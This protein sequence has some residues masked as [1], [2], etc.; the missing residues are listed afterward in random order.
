MHEFQQMLSTSLA[1]SF[2]PTILGAGGGTIES[3]SLI[4]VSTSPSRN[5]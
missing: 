2:L 4:T 5:I 1:D 3:P